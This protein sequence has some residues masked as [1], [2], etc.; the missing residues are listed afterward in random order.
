MRLLAVI[1]ATLLIAAG[2]AVTA[3][4]AARVVVIKVKSVGIAGT[5][6]V[7]DVTPK[8]PSKGDRYFGRD[9]LVNTAPQ[10]GRKVGAVV[11]T[12]WST[13]T[14]TGAKTGCVN[15]V[16]ELPGGTIRFEGCGRLGVNVPVPVTGGS[17]AY[18][19]ARGTTVAGPGTS[20]INTYRLTLP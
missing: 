1:A 3:A 9:H 16:A 19:G 2:S 12:D 15:G 8:G 5:Y 4:R 18:A 17:G 20:P 7:K 6:T 13:L 11:G 14:L 10:F